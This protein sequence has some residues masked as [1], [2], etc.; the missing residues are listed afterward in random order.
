MIRQAR[1]VA[2]RTTLWRLGLFVK[3]YWGTVALLSLAVALGVGAELL[4]PLLIQ[5]I[6]D[7]VLTARGAVGLLIWFVVGLVAARALI[8]GSAIARGWLSVRL[9]GRVAADVRGRVHQR[10]QWVPLSFFARW[11]VGALM[12]RVITDTGRLEEFFASTIPLL[13]VNCLMVAGILVFLFRTNWRLALCILIPGPLIVVAAFVL[14]DRLKLALD[15]QASA[16]SRLAAHAV[17]SLGGIQMVKA[18]GQ[19]PSE[20]VRFTRHNDRVTASAIRAERASFV[21]F[22][23]AYCLME[24]GVFLVW[25]VGGRQVLAETLQVGALLAVIS[26]LWMLHWP[27]QWAGQVSGSIGQAV[28][29]VERTFEILDAPTEPYQDPSAL[30]M[31]RAIGRVAFRAVTFGYLPGKSVLSDI[32]FDVAPGETIGIVGRSGAGK[33]TLMNLLCRF[34]DVDRGAIELDGIDIRSVRLEDLRGQIGVVAQDPFLFAGTVAEN[35]RFGR[36]TATFEEVVR[37][38]VA[39][40]AH[41]FIITKTDAYDTEIGERGRRL[42]G[43]EKQ[44]IAIAR[45]ILRDP[46]ILILDEATSLIDTPSEATIQQAVGLMAKD[47]T[48]FIIAHRLS[49]V[50]RADRILVLDRGRVVELGTPRELMEQQGLYYTFVTTQAETRSVIAACEAP[51]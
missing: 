27:L 28:V 18:F 34:Y 17:E 21:L 6:V 2:A 10:L 49:T 39:A 7:D 13:F 3:P 50:R 16:W 8:W 38:A 9:G 42:S 47:R 48:T 44:R 36:P 22:S 30:S 31:P 12:S 25:Y 26:Y 5:H 51:A 23:L 24:A 40:N 45:A 33:T 19:E 11:Q 29:G 35:I 46:R 20:A 4:P 14:W 32:S 41:S 37:A 15:R 43:G 1:T